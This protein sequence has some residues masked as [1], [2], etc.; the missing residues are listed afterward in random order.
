MKKCLYSDQSV[1]VYPGMDSE[2]MD[3]WI[4]N[5]LYFSL[6]LNKLLH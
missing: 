5:N 2:W 4:Q 6:L 3:R 1:N